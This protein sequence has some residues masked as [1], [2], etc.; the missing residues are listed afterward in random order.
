MI[1]VNEA[2]EAF[3]C[4]DL[5]QQGAQLRLDDMTQARAFVERMGHLTLERMVQA[6]L[7]KGRLQGLWIRA[8]SAWRNRPN[9][10]RIGTVLGSF[11]SPEVE[12]AREDEQAAVAWSERDHDEELH[13]GPETSREALAVALKK[14][15]ELGYGEYLE[16]LGHFCGT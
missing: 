4:A 11:L 15:A 5:T 16:D 13:V 8:G 14:L 3:V 2:A 1:E 12:A 10:Q 7:E 9:L 6:S